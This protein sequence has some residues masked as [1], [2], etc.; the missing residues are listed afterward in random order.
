MVENNNILDIKV[1]PH[2]NEPSSVIVGSFFNGLQ[3][4]E[5]TDFQ[6]YKHKKR[7]NELVLHGENDK[8]EYNGST[9]K[10]DQK[11]CVGIYDPSTKSLELLNAALIPSK[12]TSK[13]RRHLKRPAIKS[14]DV[15]RNQQRAMLGQEFGTK[16]VKKA[17]A[18]M[19]RN[20]IDS[21]KLQGEEFEIIENL[22]ET[23]KS[24]PTKEAMQKEMDEN[25]VIP[26]IS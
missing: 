13:S 6:I 9:A 4:P 24:L 14:A 11:Y 12:I 16:K 21:S 1:K 2:S 7:S 5:T 20:K 26:L 8:L 17:L 23:T 19:E 25:R 3:V 22:K 15:L 18:S 10:D